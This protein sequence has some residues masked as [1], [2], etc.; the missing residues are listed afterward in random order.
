MWLPKR[1]QDFAEAKLSANY[2]EDCIIKILGTQGAMRGNAFSD[3]L[4]LPYSM[5][6]PV[7]REMREKDLIAPAGG[8]GIGGNAGLDFGL[9]PKGIE[10]MAQ[11]SSR[12]PYFGPAPIDIQDYIVSVQSQKFQTQLVRKQH[13]DSAFSDIMISADY[14]NQLG[15]AINS[16]GPIF[17]YG[18]PGNGKTT[19]SERIARL[20]RQGMF[21]PYAIQVAG[22]VIQVFDE[23]VHRPIPEDILPANH[24]LKA[25]PKAIDPR[26]VYCFRPFIIVGGELTLEMLD[27]NFRA[28]QRCYEAPFQLKANG[29]VLL[30]DDFGRQKVKPTEFLNRWIYPLEKGMDFLQLASGKKIEVPFEQ[31]LILS[32]NL[33]PRDLGDEAFWRRIRYMIETPS[34]TDKEFK[35]IFQAICAKKKIAFDEDAYAYLVEKYYRKTNREFRSVHPRDIL[36]RVGDHINY[37]Q[38]PP[39]LTRELVDQACRAMFGGMSAAVADDA[40]KTEARMAG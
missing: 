37:H 38:L 6:E 8:S 35:C 30:V 19:M 9:T 17:L 3:L 16:G 15:P 4:K 11:I 7:I 1:P 34:P 14:L 39:K 12:T 36:N 10:Q 29:G 20:F 5:V 24:P 31:L 2:V 25:D 33:D 13:L 21:V 23:K 26:W 40:P 28:G 32:T 22:E 18:K 27:L